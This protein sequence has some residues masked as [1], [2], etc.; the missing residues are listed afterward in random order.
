MPRLPDPNAKINRLVISGTSSTEKDIRDFKEIC[1]REG[2]DASTRAMELLRPYIND[3]RPGNNQQRMDYVLTAGKPYVA[4]RKCHVRGC[5]NPGVQRMVQ[6]EK[7][8]WACRNHWKD[9]FLQGWR[10]PKP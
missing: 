2:I 8:V 10:K 4:P 7:G 6:G 3:H 1:R 9:F 5:P